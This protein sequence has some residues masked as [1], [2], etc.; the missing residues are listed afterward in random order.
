MRYD[1]LIYTANLKDVE[2]IKE[3]S[4]SEYDYYL[5]ITYQVKDHKGNEYVLVI[6]KI[7]LP[8]IKNDLPNI[9][10][11]YDDYDEDGFNFLDSEISNITKFC[12]VTKLNHGLGTKLYNPNYEKSFIKLNNDKLYLKKGDGSYKID[13][14]VY[15]YADKYFTIFNTKKAPPVKITKKE[16]EKRLGYEIEIVEEGDEY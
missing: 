16:L 12:S 6:P 7:Q 13:G 14:K 1:N 10:V 5:K 15:D 2:L 9:V 4:I 11:T 8:F 3:K